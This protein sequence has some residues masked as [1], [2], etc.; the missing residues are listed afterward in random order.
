MITPG[1][2]ALPPPPG[3][4]GLRQCRETGAEPDVTDLAEDAEQREYLV[5][6]TL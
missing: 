1:R 3:T 2:L 5:H 6:D 4:K